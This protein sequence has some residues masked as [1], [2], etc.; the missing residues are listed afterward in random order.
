MLTLLALFAHTSA[1]F[2]AFECPD[3]DLILSVKSGG[4]YQVHLC[5]HEEP[6]PVAAKKLVSEFSVHSESRQGKTAEVIPPVSAREVQFARAV[7]ARMELEETIFA[8]GSYYPAMRYSISCGKKRCT[9]SK[10]TCV[11]KRVRPKRKLNL[12]AIRPYAGGTKRHQVPDESLIDQAATL[13]YAGNRE[14]QKIFTKPRLRL[15]GAATTTF[16]LH[17]EA[18]ERLKRARCL[19]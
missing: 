19:K 6:S 9:P 8:D 2:A 13:A 12:K 11:L 7:G 4:G 16:E 17:R 18:I 10:R 1:A 3:G 15:A 14:A 5:G